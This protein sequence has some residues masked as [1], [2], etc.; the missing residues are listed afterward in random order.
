MEKR[1]KPAKQDEEEKGD[2]LSNP[3][4]P[5]HEL[6]GKLLFVNPSIISVLTIM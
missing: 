3:K 4:F 6:G 5:S 1:E 2:P